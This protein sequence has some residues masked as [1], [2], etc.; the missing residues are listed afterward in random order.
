VLEVLEHRCLPAGG[1][2]AALVA[3]ILP[4]SAGSNPAHYVVVNNAPNIAADGGVHGTGLYKSDGTAAGTVVPKDI[5]HGSGDSH[6][7]DLKPTGTT[8][9]FRADDGIRGQGP[10][11]T[12][13]T[14]PSLYA[15]STPD[16]LRTDEAL[17]SQAD[18]A[19]SNLPFKGVATGTVTGIAPSGAIIIE[20]TGN[21]THLGDFTRTEYVFFG[22]GGTISGTEVFTAA[23]GDQLSV[24]FSGAFTSPTT[25][26]GT[27]TFTGGTGRFSD[28]T[29]TATFAA[30]TL[31][32]IH[33][34]VSF[35]G[36]ISY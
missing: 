9:S 32:A 10:L 16:H 35:E 29:G 34:T 6:P 28:A 4:G 2:S 23:N 21:A 5:N 33:V 15:G 18:E 14:A 25:A 13:G 17:L 8:R 11:K 7:N 12:D 19:G 24:D 36:S 1:G 30:T 26:E 31:D 22:P 27:Y 20:S 3:D